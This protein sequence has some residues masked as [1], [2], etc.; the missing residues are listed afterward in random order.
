MC[1][2]HSTAHTAQVHLTDSSLSQAPFEF[3]KSSAKKV[4]PILLHPAPDL[5]FI[6]HTQDNTLVMAPSHTKHPAVAALK[7]PLSTVVWSFSGLCEEGYFYLS[8]LNLSTYIN[9]CFETGS[10][11]ASVE[12]GGGC[13]WDTNRKRLYVMSCKPTNGPFTI[14]QNGICNRVMAVAFLHTVH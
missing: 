8:N 6:A 4:T 14:K 1:V 7:V 13:L 12:R 10:L 9:Q 11:L 2:F 3:T 5:F